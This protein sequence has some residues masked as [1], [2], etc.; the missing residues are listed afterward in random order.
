MS[1]ELALIVPAAGR[2]SRFAKLGFSDP[3]PLLELHGRPFFWWA[4]ESVRR[5][6]PTRQII[7]VV[8]QEHID[9][10]AIDQKIRACYPDA[11]VIALADVTSGA[12]E[13]A[14]LGM[15]A[16]AAPGPVAINDCDHAFIC[17]ELAK[18]VQALQVDTE[19][20]L[21]CFRSASP[22]YSYASLGSDGRVTGTAEKQVISPFAIAGCYL[23]ADAGR[24]QELYES[25]RQ[26]CPYNELF[27]SGVFNLAAERRLPIGMIE[28]ERHCSFGTPEELEAV[29]PQVFAPYLA[30]T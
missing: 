7:F 25:Y 13:T 9:D 2:G 21:M 30:W 14:A 8:L 23:F 27:L 20:A 19:A 26:T 10:F 17:P 24:F 16:L 28:V 22:A 18:V 4:V 1:N 5:V 6:V 15:A 12:A 11:T 3:K 29:S